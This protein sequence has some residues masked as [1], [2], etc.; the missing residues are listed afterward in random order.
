M[1]VVFSGKNVLITGA[2][3][4]IGKACSLLLAYKY[5]LKVWINYKNNKA[6]AQK[7]KNKIIRKGGDAEILQADVSCEEDIKRLIKY[8]I[9]IDGKLDYLVNNAGITKDNLML[10]MSLDQ[11]NEVINNNLISSFLMTK[12]VANNMAK[13]RFGSIVNISSI[14]SKIAPIGQANY[15]ASKAGM[16]QVSKTASR[17]YAKYNVRC[18][19]VIAGLIKTKM[20]N[21][22][23]QDIL[24]DYIKDIS[25][26]KIGK[27]KDIANAVAFLLSDNAQYI[28]GSD[29]NVDGGVY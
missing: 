26:Q 9:D 1:L 8:I 11:F 22:L 27:P 5:N 18:N 23:D 6:D 16:N 24:N 13:N 3:S 21:N 19:N 20:L 12:Y 10:S 7:L 17:E 4:G 28:T 29:L 2:S 15:S 14:S 25:L